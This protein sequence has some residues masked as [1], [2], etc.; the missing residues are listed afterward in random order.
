VIARHCGKPSESSA[1]CG[2]DLW[3]GL[4][5]MCQDQRQN[6]LPQTTRMTFVSSYNTNS[7]ILIR[8]NNAEGDILI[9]S[10]PSLSIELRALPRQKRRA[11]VVGYATLKMTPTARRR[12]R[13][14][15]VTLSISCPSC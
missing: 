7:E 1:S 9:T 11:V 14:A 2:C 12:V 8:N 10:P 15:F 5:R 13:L 4:T 3:D 6:I